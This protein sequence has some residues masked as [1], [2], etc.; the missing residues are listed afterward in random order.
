MRCRACTD[1]L[2]GIVASIS[3]MPAGIEYIHSY[4]YCSPCDLYT[5]ETYKDNWTG[6]ADIFVETMDRG[7]AES[8]IA[9]IRGCPAPT[10][11]F[12]DCPVHRSIGVGW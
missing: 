5:R 2:S 7:V 12:C 11:K 3:T 6:D 1:E 8:K 10:D 4:A 9:Q